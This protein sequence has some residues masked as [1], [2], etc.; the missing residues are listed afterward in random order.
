[1]SR[2][3][4]LLTLS[5]TALCAAAFAQPVTVNGGG[6]ASQFFNYA[7][8]D[9]NGA[10]VSELSLYNSQQTRVSFGTYWATISGAA[11]AA[12]LSNDL[13]CLENAQ[14]GNNGGKCSNQPGG[15]NTTHYGVSESV[16]S[17]NSVATWA[18]SSWGQSAAGDLIQIPA[19]GTGLAIPVNDTN[20]TSNGQIGF[21]DND[22]CGI[23]SGLITNFSQITDGPG[24]LDAGM[25]E[26]LYRS[27]SA[28]TTFLLTNHLAAVCNSANTAPGVT[29]TPTSS[30]ASLF[31]TP[32]TNQIP[33]A[34]GVNGL[35][36]LANTMAGLVNGPIPQAISYISPDWTSV[37][38]GT[39]SAKLSNGLPSPL[40]VAG[41]RNGARFYIP[42]VANIRAALTHVKVGTNQTPPNNATDG[43]NPLKWVPIVQI[44]ATGYPIVGYS[45]LEFAQCYGSAAVSKG[46]V[47]FLHDHYITAPYYQIENNNGLVTVANGPGTKWLNAIHFNILGNKNHWNV[48]I[49]N[50]TACAGLAG[51]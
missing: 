45:T 6:A 16:F 32:I 40:L 2:A 37:D 43:A 39:S 41:L 19:L 46:I 21:S 28:G 7:A 23:F 24:S 34:V 38:S 18:T 48:N 27:D 13:T 10:P 47:G 25:F 22:L 15:A 36:T 14:T 3:L 42:T 26:L 11:Q 4:L 33:G 17:A 51:R 5:N 49:G 1:M 30:F 20:L 8:P 44:A 9:V 31:G 50:P 12:M 29:F 35:A